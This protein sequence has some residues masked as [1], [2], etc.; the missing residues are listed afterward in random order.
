MAAYMLLKIM[1]SLWEILTQLNFLKNKALELKLSE[2]LF[3][4]IDNFP[5]KLAEK[6]ADNIASFEE[7]K[8]CDLYYYFADIIPDE[9]YQLL[10]LLPKNI[11]LPSGKQVPIDYEDPKAPLIAAKIQ[12]FF[13]WNETPKIADGRLN[14][15][16]ELLAPNM[17]PAQTTSDLGYFWKNSY[18]DV[19]KDL[20]ARYPKHSWPEDPTQ[21]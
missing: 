17:R 18:V 19:R 10:H 16:L 5:L 7:F 9:I 13:G 11:R 20:R 3:A 8:D 12:D 4:F 2:N 15:T 6:L 14:L 1:K 21:I